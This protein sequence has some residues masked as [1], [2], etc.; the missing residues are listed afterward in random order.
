MFNNLQWSI[1]KTP[2]VIW[3]A[4][5]DYSRI[6]WKHTLVDLEKAGD[7]VYQDILNE[8][9]STWGVKGLIVTWSSLLP[10]YSLKRVK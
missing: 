2:Q 9:D 3:D 8:I 7:M 4:L 10:V 6:E 5:Q 1:E